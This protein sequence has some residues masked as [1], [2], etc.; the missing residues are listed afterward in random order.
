M[1]K[2]RFPT[3]FYRLLYS[4]NKNLHLAVSE[5]LRLMEKYSHRWEECNKGV[6][7]LSDFCKAEDVAEIVKRI[8]EELPHFS[9]FDWSGVA[10]GGGYVCS[11]VLRVLKAKG[12]PSKDVDIFLFKDIDENRKRIDKHLKKEEFSLV[13]RTNRVNNYMISE[14]GMIHQVILKNYRSMAEMLVSFDLDASKICYS[15]GKIY[16]T[17]RFLLQN[18]Y[19][20]PIYSRIINDEI[21]IYNGYADRLHKYLKN[22]EVPIVYPINR[23]DME[24]KFA[25][26]EDM[27]PYDVGLKYNIPRKIICTRIYDA[28]YYNLLMNDQYMI[29]TFRD[30]Q[31]LSGHMELAPRLIKDGIAYDKYSKKFLHEFFTWIQYYNDDVSGLLSY[32]LEDKTLETQTKDKVLILCMSIKRN[33]KNL[34]TALKFIFQCKKFLK[35]NLTTLLGMEY[36][37]NDMF[38]RVKD[39]VERN[40]LLQ[41]LNVSYP[42]SP[43]KITNFYEL[44]GV[45][46]V[47]L[48]F[49]KIYH[50]ITM[51]HQKRFIKKNI[52]SLTSIQILTAACEEENRSILAKSL[53][54]EYT[55]KYVYDVVQSLETGAPLSDNLKI[56]DY[57]DK[58]LKLFTSIEDTSISKCYD[59]SGCH[60]TKLL[61][62]TTM[63]KF[64]ELNASKDMIMS[65]EKLFFSLI[66]K[67]YELVSTVNEGS[68]TRDLKSAFS[69]LVIH[70]STLLGLKG[71]DFTKKPLENIV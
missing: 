36:F 1:I 51:E 32:Y 2:F 29:P 54:E 11:K 43:E 33:R 31:M 58:L 8:K 17:R 26:Y 15:D 69:N 63:F 48:K 12:N 59:Q 20:L 60:Q 3:S 49:G 70:Y 10:I 22:K 66:Y 39:N 37:T 53:R 18:N 40:L 45:M 5:E 56:C 55:E 7:D 67:M 57:I 41:A 64:V 46:V 13:S 61:F 34:E 44:I 71:K 9:D 50:E 28:D 16:V 30:L 21:R 25:R 14:E 24:L 47:N 23:I 68:W 42:P 35:D 52:K 19:F 65:R 6:Y 27:C 4:N 62:A 38:L